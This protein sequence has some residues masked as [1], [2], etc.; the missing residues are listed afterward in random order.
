MQV[1]SPAVGVPDA[2][3]LTLSGNGQNY[4]RDVTLH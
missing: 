3:V 1:I 4:G 2:V